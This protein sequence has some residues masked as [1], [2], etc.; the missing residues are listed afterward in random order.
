MILGTF[1]WRG[2]KIEADM[3]ANDI[4]GETIWLNRVDT[5]TAI[6]LGIIRGGRLFPTRFAPTDDLA[7]IQLRSA[8]ESFRAD[9][10]ELAA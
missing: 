3:I 5:G 6:G 2:M 9:A 1:P 4:V 8:F 10:S 7:V